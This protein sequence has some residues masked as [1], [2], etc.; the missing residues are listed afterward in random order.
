MLL[1][2]VAINQDIKIGLLRQKIQFGRAHRASARNLIRLEYHICFD[3][4]K[5]MR[6]TRMPSILILENQTRKEF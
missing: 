3:Q 5:A 6:I 1:K 2:S 4:S